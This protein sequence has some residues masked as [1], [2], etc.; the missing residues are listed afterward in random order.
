[1]ESGLAAHT[2]MMQ[3]EEHQHWRGL[4]ADCEKTYAKSYA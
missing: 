2:P 3:E 1:M 4:R